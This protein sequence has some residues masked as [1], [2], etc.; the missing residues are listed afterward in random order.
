MANEIA[1]K[2]IMHKIIKF[3]SGART[4]NEYLI[5]SVNISHILRK[6]I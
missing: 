6:I 3:N 4:D 2:S 5:V 1:V